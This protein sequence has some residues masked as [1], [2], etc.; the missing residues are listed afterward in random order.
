MDTADI[1][2]SYPE[3]GASDEELDRES[4]TITAGSVLSDEEVN[5]IKRETHDETMASR[6]NLSEE[7]HTQI[8]TVKSLCE[9]E[10]PEPSC[11]SMKSDRSMH[12]PIHFSSG[13]SSADL[14]L[15]HKA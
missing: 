9:N 2:H 15:K 11:V 14:R 12:H 10:S 5:Y 13:D 3:G 1:F 7:H 8:K 6:M 4:E